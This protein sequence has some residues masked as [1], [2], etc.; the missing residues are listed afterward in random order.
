MEKGTE[1]GNFEIA[2]SFRP[3]AMKYPAVVH[4]LQT[5]INDDAISWM[6]LL[7]N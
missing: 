6:R 3:G 4:L 1:C 7:Q 2:V 5:I